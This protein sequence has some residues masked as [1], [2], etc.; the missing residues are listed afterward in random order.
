MKKALNLSETSVL[1]RTTW[2]NIP[3]DTILHRK[4]TTF[5]KLNM[6]P[7]SGGGRETPNLLGVLEVNNLQWSSD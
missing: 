3:E 4:N 6:L 2:N 5:L 1:T 7:S